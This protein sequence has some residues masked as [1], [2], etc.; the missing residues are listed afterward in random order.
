MMVDASRVTDSYLKKIKDDW[1]T[2]KTQHKAAI[3][4]HKINF[5]K[6]LRGLLEKRRPLY[7]DASKM[8]KGDIVILM[9]AKI[10][11]IKSNGQEI[12][13]VAQA[14]KT[15]I[16]GMGDPAE[17]ALTSKLDWII[18]EAAEYDINYAN[19]MLKK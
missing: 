6:D 8:K 11:S 18:T 5:N 12:K 9:R 2:L 15:K 10:N 16:H 14:Y 17:K 19:Y 13:T 4:A 7:K 3:D 1:S